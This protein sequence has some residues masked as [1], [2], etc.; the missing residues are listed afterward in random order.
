VTPNEQL[1]LLPF[2]SLATQSTLVVPGWKTDP[3]AGAH[4][5]VTGCA[6]PAMEGAS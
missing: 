6:P 2:A 4:L 5:L 3:D 1:A